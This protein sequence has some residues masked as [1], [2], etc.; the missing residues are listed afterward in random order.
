[1][2]LVRR[3][4]LPIALIL[5]STSLLVSSCGDDENAGDL[6][7]PR[8]QDGVPLLPDPILSIEPTFATTDSI[9]RY[10]K[11]TVVGQLNRV[12]L[13]AREI[14]S[15]H[16]ALNGRG[17]EEARPGC[18]MRQ[19]GEPA[20]TAC[21]S[22]LWVCEAEGGF[23]YSHVLN[24]PC[25]PRPNGEPPIQ[26][27]DW[28]SFSGFS[29]ADA[30]RGVFQRFHLPGYGTG[31][32]AEWTWEVSTDG[33]FVDWMFYVGG[34]R[35]S[36]RFAGAYRWDRRDP[37]VLRG[38]FRWSDRGKW[39]ADV[40]GDGRSGR[41]SILTLDDLSGEWRLREEIIWR[42]AH[43]TWDSYDETGTL[44]SARVW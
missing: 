44:T 18:R 38:E 10:A 29:N 17:W 31:P 32:S 36:G 20:D 21:T 33:A 8:L 9:A 42:P 14:E 27:T 34:D 43:G 1:M 13:V 3:T 37:S 12:G 16:T 11:G 39:N 23:S 26:L 2:P 6:S 41:M 25:V 40:A 35:S 5:L 4:F 7:R 19:F 22:A 28:T 30:T 24:G 15:A